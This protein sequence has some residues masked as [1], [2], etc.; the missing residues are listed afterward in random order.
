M[1]SSSQTNPIF[2][3]CPPTPAVQLCNNGVHHLC[4]LLYARLPLTLNNEIHF[5]SIHQWTSWRRWTT[6]HA[7][8][9][10]SCFG[11]FLQIQTWVAAGLSAEAA[12]SLRWLL[13]GAEALPVQMMRTLQE[14]LPRISLFFGYGPTEASEHV[15]C[16]A[17]KDLGSNPVEVPILVGQPIPHTHIYIVDSQWQLMPVGV[18]GELLTSGVG[19]ARGYLNRPDLTEQAFCAQQLG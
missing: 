1:T 18:P 5:S 7:N 17:F 16:K 13:T 3:S 19:L 9:Q 14:R 10:S 6:P 11:L 8:A 2:L 4:H 12:P 15:T